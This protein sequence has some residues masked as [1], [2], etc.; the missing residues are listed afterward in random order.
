MKNE[1]SPNPSHGAPTSIGDSK[2][3]WGQERRL[4]FIDLRLQYDGKIRRG[5][6]KDYFGISIQQASQDLSQYL[7]LAPRN[8]RY[9]SSSKTYV[10]TNEFFPRYGQPYAEPYLNEIRAIAIGVLNTNTYK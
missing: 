1:Q 4:A 2:A 9:D 7:I 6:L 5:D 3:R 8:M 10:S